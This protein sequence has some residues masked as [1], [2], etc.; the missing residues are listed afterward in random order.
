VTG[1]KRRFATNPQTKEGTTVM[2]SIV[3]HIGASFAFAIVWLSASTSQAQECFLT[4]EVIPSKDASVIVGDEVYGRLAGKTF[5]QWN[6]FTNHYMTVVGDFLIANFQDIA[7]FQDPVLGIGGFEGV[8]NPNVLIDLEFSP[9]LV[10]NELGKAISAITATV[11]YSWIQDG[12]VAYCDAEVGADYGNRNSIYSIT[13][14]DGFNVAMGED[15]VKSAYSTIVNANDDNSI[16]YT[17]DHEWM[18]MLGRVDVPG[19]ITEA[20]EYLANLYSSNIELNWEVINDKWTVYLGNNWIGDPNGT[21]LL[22]Y[23][24]KNLYP[25]LNLART[26]YLVTLRMFVDGS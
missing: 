5:A 19:L 22:K 4:F 8:S 17:F 3:R 15:F 7:K 13:P 21:A 16:G 6:D 25:D 2:K 23:V 9:P 14:G 12:T 10:D 1:T 11:G 18:F 20:N 24:N 26:N